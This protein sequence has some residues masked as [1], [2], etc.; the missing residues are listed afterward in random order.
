M[1]SISHVDLTTKILYHQIYHTGNTVPLE[2]SPD[3]LMYANGKI[4]KAKQVQIGDTLSTNATVSFVSVAYVAGLYAPLTETGTLL[5]SGAPVSNFVAMTT[6]LSPAVQHHAA[7]AA[8][9]PVRWLCRADFDFC[10]YQ[11]YTDSHSNFVYGP[12]LWLT[13][14][15]QKPTL[16]QVGVALFI[17]PLLAVL[18]TLDHYWEMI[19]FRIVPIVQYRFKK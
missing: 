15:V 17:T 14:L 10:R 4:V 12:I 19:L 1:Y 8:L 5:V 3:H 6:L 13:A 11:S 2:I 18:F 9:A 7:H 16:I